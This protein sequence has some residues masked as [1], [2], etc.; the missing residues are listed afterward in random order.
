MRDIDLSGVQKVKLTIYCGL[1]STGNAR[2]TWLSPRIYK[3]KTE[4]EPPKTNE[5]AGPAADAAQKSAGAG[6][7]ATFTLELPVAG[8]KN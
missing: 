4:A 7:G 5:A 3:A 6:T 2:G 8:G 1:G